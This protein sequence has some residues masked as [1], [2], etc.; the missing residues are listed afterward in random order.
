M[1]TEA[2]VDQEQMR[3]HCLMRRDLVFWTTIPRGRV[4]EA[5]F[6]LA[7]SSERCETALLMEFAKEVTRR[8]GD[9]GMNF[10]K[11]VRRLARAA[12]DLAVILHNP[13]LLLAFVVDEKQRLFSRLMAAQELA[14][15]FKSEEHTAVLVGL[16]RELSPQF[17]ELLRCWEGG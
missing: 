2:I 10:A 12:C 6:W 13:N 8:L 11:Y 7:F 9:N 1:T 16:L 4:F 5:L 15:R 3:Q 14:I 17:P